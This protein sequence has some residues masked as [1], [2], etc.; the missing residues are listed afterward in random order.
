VG[1][2]KSWSANGLL[3]TDFIILFFLKFGIRFCNRFDG[4]KIKKRGDMKKKEG[5][6]EKEGGDDG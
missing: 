5:E 2:I 1:E 3:K 6:H 4:V